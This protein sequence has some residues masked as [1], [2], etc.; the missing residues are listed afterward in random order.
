MKYVKSFNE[1]IENR[2]PDVFPNNML[3]CAEVMKEKLDKVGMRYKL[4][5]T[6]E[7]VI[8]YTLYNKNNEEVIISIESDKDDN[9]I[10]IGTYPNS[11]QEKHKHNYREDHTFLSNSK[12]WKEFFHYLTEINNLDQGKVTKRMNEH[13]WNDELDEEEKQ[14]QHS[15]IK[16]SNLLDKLYNADNNGISL[17]RMTKKILDNFH[18][19]G[20]N[21]N[22]EEFQYTKDSEG[23][24]Q[25]LFYKDDRR[26]P[27]TKHLSKFSSD[28]LE[29]FYDHLI[30]LVDIGNIMKKINK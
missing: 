18:K 9:T 1:T 24:K 30:D 14:L 27:R 29:S 19:K 21:T 13:I 4:L 5:G 20:M 3:A 25:T 16:V 26:N 11:Y 2:H 7:Y 6:N 12:N 22:I 17:R 23:W 15:I 28:L 10:I 8:N